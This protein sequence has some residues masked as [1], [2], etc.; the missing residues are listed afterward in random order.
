MENGFDHD[1]RLQPTKSQWVTIN[2]PQGLHMRPAYVFAEAAS[3]FQSKIELVKNDLRIDGKSVLSI[4]TLGA[5]QGT[6]V[7][8]EATG[9]DACDAIEVLHRLLASGFSFNQRGDGNDQN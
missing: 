1:S 2:N 6:Q 8:I 3:K 4:L 9:S 7:L 5:S